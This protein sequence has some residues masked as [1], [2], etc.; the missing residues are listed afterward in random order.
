MTSLYKT[1]RSGSIV[2]CPIRQKS[3]RAEKCLAFTWGVSIAVCFCLSLAVFLR[4]YYPSEPSGDCWVPPHGFW[5]S[6]FGVGPEN[7]PYYNLSVSCHFLS[8]LCCYYFYIQPTHWLF[9]YL[10]APCRHLS[11]QPRHCVILTPRNSG[12]SHLILN[13]H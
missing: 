13:S 7:L 2:P 8:H 12:P 5:F 1:G 6:K 11:L 9:F 4:C 3:H 10:H